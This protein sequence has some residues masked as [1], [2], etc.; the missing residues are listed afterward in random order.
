M[1]VKDLKQLMNRPDAFHS[2]IAELKS[3]PNL[4]EELKGFL[5]LYDTYN[6][7]IT[8]LKSYFSETKQLILGESKQKSSYTY[9]KY[10]AVIILL[11]GIGSIFL[12]MNHA[13][14]PHSLAVFKEP[15]IPILMGGHPKI[16]WGSLMFAIEEESSE[17]AIIEWKKIQKIAPENDSVNYFGGVVYFN[18]NQ[19]SKAEIYFK[20]N[21]KVE[22]TYNDRSLYF[23]AIIDWKRNKRAEA[24]KKLLQLTSTSDLELKKAVKIHLEDIK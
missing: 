20:Q 7:D 9:L 16:E 4:S 5:F 18:A 3:H 13:K 24:K 23:L 1:D 11:V 12:F 21:L 2:K 14:Q 8:A 6:G 15:G 10:A 17:K 19:F 22:S